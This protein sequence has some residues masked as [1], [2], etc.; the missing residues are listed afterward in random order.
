LVLLYTLVTRC[1][2]EEGYSC[3][4]SEESLCDD[5]GL[6][7]KT[8]KGAANVLVE[9]DLIKKVQRFNNSNLWYI[10]AAKLQAMAKKNEAERK[11]KKA[12]ASVSPFAPPIVSTRPK[13]GPTAA[14]QAV[15]DGLDSK[16]TESDS[17]LPKQKVDKKQV[18]EVITLLKTHFGEHNTFK[19]EDVDII[20]ADCAQHCIRIAGD[21]NTCLSVFEW[22]FQAEHVLTAVARADFLG[23]YIKSRFEDWFAE[24]EECKEGDDQGLS[25]DIEAADSDDDEEQ[26]G[27]A[28]T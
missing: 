16:P 6:G 3:F 21:S 15:V 20:M 22:I 8:V 4:P 23:G 25:D 19:E 1:T 26:I 7:L 27:R 13:P 28:V 17:K 11:A 24:F 18:D 14:E 12:E 9:A 10:N 2:P 5:T